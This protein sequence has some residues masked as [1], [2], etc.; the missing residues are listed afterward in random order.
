MEVKVFSKVDWVIKD[1][2]YYSSIRKHD[3][4]RVDRLEASEIRPG[5]EHVINVPSV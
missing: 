3:A 2:G 4:K 5:M 1:D